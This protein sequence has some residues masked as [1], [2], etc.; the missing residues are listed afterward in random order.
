MRDGRTA[1]FPQETK[2]R[3]G[4]RSVKPE[5]TFCMLALFE[6]GYREQE[7]AGLT[8]DTKMDQ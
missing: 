3:S 5:I 8:I 6:I 1:I 7:H 4:D 2:Y